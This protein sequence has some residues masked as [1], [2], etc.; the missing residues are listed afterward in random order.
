M[1]NSNKLTY[2]RAA[3]GNLQPKQPCGGN[4]LKNST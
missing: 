3:R 2:F 4:L 1:G